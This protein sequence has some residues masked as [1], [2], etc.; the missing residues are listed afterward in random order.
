M[1]SKLGKLLHTYA[2]SSD[3]L[4]QTITKTILSMSELIGLR[5]KVAKVNAKMKKEEEKA[6]MIFVTSDS[7]T[8]SLEATGVNSKLFKKAMVSNFFFNQNKL[9]LFMENF[10]TLISELESYKEKGLRLNPKRYD[11]VASKLNLVLFN[12]TTEKDYF[13][14]LPIN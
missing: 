4:K 1:K 6:L 14:T 3:P 5:E 10:V 7:V 11:E 8:R 12:Y 13:T 9:V 2:K